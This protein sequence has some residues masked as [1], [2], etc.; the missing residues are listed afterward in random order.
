MK[1]T[2]STVRVRPA[3]GAACAVHKRLSASGW[4]RALPL[5]LCVG[6][7]TAVETVWTG[8]AGEG[9]SF[10]DLSDN[11][12]A[13]LPLADT[14]D[15]QLG[16]HDTSVREGDFRLR[17]VQGNG[18]LTMEGGSL[19]IADNGSWLAALSLR[20]G[21]LQGGGA[22][23]TRSLLWASGALGTSPEASP[24]GTLR[25]I[26]AGAVRLEGGPTRHIEASA[27]VEWRGPTQWVDDGSQLSVDGE[28]RVGA[29][30]WWQDHANENQHQLTLGSGRF[31][32]HGLY[33]KTGIAGTNVELRAPGASFE[34]HGFF[35]VLQGQ[36]NVDGGPG[37]T[38]RNA[39]TLT[40]QGGHYGISLYRS[41][42]VLHSG[43]L[44]VDLGRFSLTTFG[45]GLNSTGDWNVAR[46]GTVYLRATPDPDADAD[47]DTPAANAH[48]F[49]AGAF[50]N[51]GRLILDETR[52]VFRAGAWLGG[53][54]RIEVRRGASLEVADDLLAGAL[55]VEESRT[56]YRSETQV[57]TAYSSVDVA[58]RLR[59]TTLEWGAGRLHASGGIRVLEGAWLS[60]E[61]QYRGED[62]APVFGKRLDTTLQLDGDNQWDG[63]G[64]LFG[65]GR[66]LVGGSAIFRDTNPSGTPSRD[67]SDGR[68]PTRIA[69][70]G[71]DNDG[72][73]L[74]S[75]PGR[76][77]IRSPFR[78]RGTVGSQ[79]EGGLRFVGPLDNTGTLEAVRSRIDVDAPLAQW[80]ADH[81]R[82]QGGHYVMRDGRIALR[83]GLEA[84]GRTPVGLRE[85]AAT[86]WLEGPQAQLVN[87]ATG[88]DH[89]ALAGLERNTGRLRLQEGAVLLLDTEL[90]NAGVL[91]VGEGSRLGVQ[92]GRGRY[93][94]QD[95]TA[96]TWVAGALQAS[97]LLI[98]GG[99]L[100]AGLKGQVGRAQ[101][102]ATRVLLTGGVLDIEVETADSFDRISADG[103][104]VLGGIDLWV[105]MGSAMVPGTYRVLTA[106]GGLSGTFASLGSNADPTLFHLVPRYGRDY[107]DL[108]VTAAPEP[109]TWGLML[110]G[111]VALLGVRRRRQVS[112]RTGSP[113]GR[114]PTGAKQFTKM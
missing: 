108:T 112:A 111:L 41:A 86:L 36:V 20:D 22:L 24:G 2:T 91:E 28:L 1:R 3:P 75:G 52:A 101:L 23:T 7:A 104:V 8:G 85:N 63:A 50:L 53:G 98:Q 31:V 77:E 82:L 96:A 6:S 45:S 48:L 67:G 55:Q 61:A 47:P 21:R 89:N 9:Q 11:W 93:V 32:N 66:V 29:A 34:N 79:G 56:L 14:V 90:R 10:W 59:L 40:V 102:Q 4:S 88:A 27:D 76:T 114:S 78:N 30:G 113:V 13:G 74:K 33:Q 84:D 16:D 18:R 72:H 46:E 105:E 65:S 26:V 49:S 60:G 71:F 51:E 80:D 94:Q 103:A 83:L 43:T 5:L 109:S 95:D 57:G 81:R 87:P 64:D 58:G 25:F 42:D 100:G 54:G 39:G 38:W 99:S 73:Y 19:H 15:V 69:L 70:A 37:T 68:R 17:R 12:S 107:L 62:G 44:N 35:N 92:R 97:D 106:A 110:L